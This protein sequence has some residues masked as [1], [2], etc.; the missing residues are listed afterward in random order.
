[1]I[2]LAYLR[3][4]SAKYLKDPFSLFEVILEKFKAYSIIDTPSYIRNIQLSDE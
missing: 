2:Y 3:E 4:H 1:M